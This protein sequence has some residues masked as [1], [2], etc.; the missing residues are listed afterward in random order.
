MLPAWFEGD[1]EAASAGSQMVLGTIEYLIARRR[2]EIATLER[3]AD[4]LR[5]GES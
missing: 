4:L 3:M 5:G 2:E 1:D